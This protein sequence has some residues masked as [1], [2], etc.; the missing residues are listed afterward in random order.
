MLSFD[1]TCS[2]SERTATKMTI[3]ELKEKIKELPDD[4]PVVCM[5]MG[6]L[7]EGYAIAY[8]EFTGVVSPINDINIKYEDENIPSKVF[9]VRW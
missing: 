7:G 6:F 8:S 9:I 2:E 5:G 3:G 4:M 1:S